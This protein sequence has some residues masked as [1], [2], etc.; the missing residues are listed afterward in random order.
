MME[1]EK[2]IIAI[3][4]VQK[5]LETCSFDWKKNE[6]LICILLDMLLYE[7]SE[8]VHKAFEL[9]FRLF[10]RYNRLSQLLRKVQLMENPEAIEVIS[11]VD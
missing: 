8:L 11:K 7:D 2:R 6:K 9:L 3:E 4:W 10:S 5:A 1:K